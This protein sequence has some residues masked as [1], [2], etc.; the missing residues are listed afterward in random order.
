MFLRDGG[1]DDHLKRVRPAYRERR[2]RMLDALQ[3]PFS[4]RTPGGRARRAGCS[5]GSRLPEGFDGDDL[6]VAAR[7]AGV[8]YSRGELFHS[9]GSGAQHVAPDLFGGLAGADRGRR[10]HR[11]AGWSANAGPIALDQARQSAAETMPI[12]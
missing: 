8:L 1:L 11:W 5:S 6:F 9:D 4:P 12:F 7:Q 2:D 3:T 10:G